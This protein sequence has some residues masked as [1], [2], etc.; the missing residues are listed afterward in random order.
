M[1]KDSKG[2]EMSVVS[3]LHL[4]VVQA[5]VFEDNDPYDDDEK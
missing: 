2:R 1:F 3:P 4:K 5:A